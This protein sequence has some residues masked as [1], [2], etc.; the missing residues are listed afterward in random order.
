[1]RIVISFT[2]YPPRINCVY[3]VVESLYRQT[4]PADEIVLYLS[5]DEFPDAEADLPERLIELIGRGGFRIE[6]KP[7]NLKSHKKYYYALQEYRDAV[8]ITVDDDKV[9]AQTMI[10]DLIE[11]YRRFPEAVSA[12]NARIMLRRAETVESYCRWENRKYMEEYADIP[13]MDLCAI[14]V[15]GICY[16]PALVKA[17]WFDE[18]AILKS[19]EDHDDLW[20]KYNEVMC[21]IPVVYTKPSGEDITIDHSQT[22]SLAASNLYGSRNDECI[23]R[24]FAMIKERDSDHCREWFRNLMTWE[25]YL[26][27]KKGYYAEIFGNVFDKAG[28]LPVYFYGA[29]RIARRYFMVLEDLALLKRITAIIVSDRAG[30][31]PVLYGLQVKVLSELDPDKEF[32][33]ILGVNEANRKEVRDRLAAYDHRNIELD[34]RIILRYYQE[35][36]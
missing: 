11:S 35:E 21:N 16:P 20:L 19:A 31:P 17:E 4:I 29:G 24:L 33:V 15:G 14:G 32:A 25:A 18:A 22:C 10:E 3:Q 8:V 23:S 13:R 2:S 5:M 12:R 27:A 1:M 34:M 7:G 6:W 28:D 30:N 26:A 9:Y 36:V